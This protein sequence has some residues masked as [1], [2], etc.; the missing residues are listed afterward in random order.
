MNYD[1]AQFRECYIPGGMGLNHSGWW[2]CVRVQWHD[3]TYYDKPVK[4][5][6]RA[7][8]K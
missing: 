7:D 6:R 3:G 1:M 4:F 2:L 8:Y 5:L